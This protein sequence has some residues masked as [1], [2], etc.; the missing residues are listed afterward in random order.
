MKYKV[1]DKIKVKTSIGVLDGKVERLN[2]DGRYTVSVVAKAFACDYGTSICHIT[3]KEEDI[4]KE[5]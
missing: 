3:S 1:G 2:S 5:R 4:S